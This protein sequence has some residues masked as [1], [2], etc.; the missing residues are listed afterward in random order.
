[1]N[2]LGIIVALLI[3]S[4]LSLIVLFLFVEPEFLEYALVLFVVSISLLILGIVTFEPE[5]TLEWLIRN[6]ALTL[7]VVLFLM[8][9]PIWP[10]SVQYVVPREGTMSVTALKNWTEF[11]TFPYVAAHGFEWYDYQAPY[12]PYQAT[13]TIHHNANPFA[14]L[15][16]IL[17]AVFGVVVFDRKT[18]GRPTDNSLRFL[19]RSGRT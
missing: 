9:M 15:A 13:V 14:I 19:P 11:H 5:T 7:F 10:V 4:V 3:F 17:I 18:G 12:P 8:S 2:K 6:I 1:M 16:I